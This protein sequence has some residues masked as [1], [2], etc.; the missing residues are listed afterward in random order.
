MRANLIS[1]N[2]EHVEYSHD[3]WVTGNPLV[4][5][6]DPPNTTPPAASRIIRVDPAAR[7]A[8]AAIALGSI[9]VIAIG[10][11]SIVY[12]PWVFDATLN[13]WL[14]WGAATTVTLG[15]TN[16]GAIGIGAMLGAK[17]FLQI[18]TV[19]GAVTAFGYGYV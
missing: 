10:G 6:P 14:L 2:V 15:T 17:W 19:N 5:D 8:A 7:N 13:L 9:R 11:T 16:I 4:A 18:T 12:K 3:C 1:P